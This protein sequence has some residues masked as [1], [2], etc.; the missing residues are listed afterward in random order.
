MREEEAER[1]EALAAAAAE[2][3][4]SS[5]AVDADEGMEG[6]DETGMERDLDGE[7]PEAEEDPDDE[8]DGLVEE[9]EEGLEEDDVGVDDEE[10]YMERDLDDDIPDAGLE[11]DDF[12]MQGDLDDEIPVAGELGDEGM[13]RDLDDDIPSAAEVGSAQG[14]EWQHTDTEAEMDDDDEDDEGEFSH[15]MIEPHLRSSTSS[16]LP[17]VRREVETEAQRRFLQR[18]SGGADALDT[19]MLLDDQ[20]LHASMVSQSSRTSAGFARFPRRTG[21]PRDSLE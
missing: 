8:E 3:A 19:S 5:A 20:S 13:T 4:A 9:G 15:E 18:W 14:E 16:G 6:E 7:I 21:G 12:D 10:G 11:E 17:P 2:M 1:E